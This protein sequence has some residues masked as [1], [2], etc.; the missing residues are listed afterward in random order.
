MPDERGDG[1]VF[2]I[3]REVQRKFWDPPLGDHGP[4]V[5]SYETSR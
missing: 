2:R 5:R 3:C 4:K 1:N